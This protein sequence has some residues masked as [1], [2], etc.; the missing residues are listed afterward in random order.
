[1]PAYPMCPKC[2][3]VLELGKYKLPNARRYLAFIQCS[4]C[5]TAIGVVDDHSVIDLKNR[6]NDIKSQLDR[7]LARLP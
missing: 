4:A 5:H 3:S 1:M 7:I 2:G 6:M